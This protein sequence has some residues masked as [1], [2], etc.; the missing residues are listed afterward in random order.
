V[1]RYPAGCDNHS[2]PSVDPAH[3]AH[4]VAGVDDN[5][6]AYDLVL[7]A[8][9]LSAL[10]AM[11]ALVVAGGFALALRRALGRGG[12]L[13]VAVVRYFRPGV[14]WVGRVLFLVPVLG[15]ALI[16]MSGGQW[17]YSDGWVTIGLGAW[18]VVAFVAEGGLWPAER[19]LQAE[20]AT[21]EAV[22]GAGARA[23]A[24]A[25]GADGAAPT[26][27]PVAVCLRTG[28]LG[29]GLAVVLVA[30]AVLMVAKP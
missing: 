1:G 18:V 28:L 30:V 10:V 16:A 19:R 8:H 24:E 2:V 22:D 7:L 3:L 13:P 5:S 27:D 21:R 20:V 17:G 4:L 6:A 11:V 29:I 23:P 14:N 25:D 15:V 26:V 9:V 12:P